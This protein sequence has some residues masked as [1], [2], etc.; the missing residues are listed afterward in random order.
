MTRKKYD[1]DDYE[2]EY[3]QAEEIIGKQVV[4]GK[5]NKYLDQEEDNYNDFNKIVERN[6]EKEEIENAYFAIKEFAEKMDIQIF[7]PIRLDHWFRF[8]ELE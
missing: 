4:F 6:R 7:T 2:L 3:E 5:E 1:I 8:F